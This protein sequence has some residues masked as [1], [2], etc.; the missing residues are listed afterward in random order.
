M[1]NKLVG[2]VLV[3]ALAFVGVNEG[4]R[5]TAYQDS[6]GWW[7]ICNGITKGVKRGD[8]ATPAECE[9]LL[10]RELI[11]HARPLEA[12]PYQLPDHVIVAWADFSY[13]LGVGT[14]R[15]STGYKL[16]RQGRV[17]ESCRNILAYRFVTVNK[18]KLD[19]F[20][21]ENYRVCG[22]IK[23]RRTTEYQLCAGQITIDEAIARMR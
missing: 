11:A 19:C 18:V 23:K 6:G 3:A 17:A 2:G 14:F 7:T 15:S 10:M 21:D 8:T 22:G 9:S 5:Y 13:N 1:N 20:L 16:L 4:I 12:I